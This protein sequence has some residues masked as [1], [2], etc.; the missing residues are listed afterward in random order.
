MPRWTLP[1]G[2]GESRYSREGKLEYPI[3]EQQFI[4][5]MKQGH[6]VNM[7]HQAYCILLYYIGIR[8]L[9]GTMLKGKDFSLI[10]EDKPTTML[11]TVTRLKH[12]K[13]TPPV[14]IPLDAPYVDVLRKVIEVTK[15][16]KEVFPFCD[17]TAY[18]AVR[19][20]FKYPHWFRLSRITW[21]FMPHPEV[22]RP[23]GFTIAEVR[24][25]TGLSLKALDYYVG[26]V[27][28][29]KMGEAMNKKC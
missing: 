2:S 27:A 7:K 25:W 9:E 1:K 29:Q 19:R 23:S 3:T 17:R 14:P 26:L 20:V 22:D 5:G 24:S 8:R 15:P 6:F 13:H 28:I 16:N 12:S 11:V 4:E 21:F 10:P 18:N